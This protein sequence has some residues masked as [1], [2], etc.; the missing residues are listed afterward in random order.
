[1]ISIRSFLLSAIPLALLVSSG[2]R[3]DAIFTF[4]NV[5]AGTAIPFTDTVNGLT[6][7]FSGSGT[8][9]DITTANFATLSGNALIQ[10]FC[11]PTVLGA[12]T[13]NFSSSLSAVSLDFATA[14]RPSE[15][16]TLQAYQGSALVGTVNLASS[17]PPGNF[18]N[19]EG[20]AS[21]SGT[22]NSIVLNTVG[23]GGAQGGPFAI[24]SINAVT[25]T[26]GVPEPAS[27]SMFAAGGVALLALA[28]R[29][30]KS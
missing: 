26:S 19:G 29:I 2:A 8:V 7:S 9:C 15:P 5:A 16:F 14:G 10:G 24:D 21:F 13:V 30:R 17:V 6:A 3:A 22:F 1:M 18:P 11:G 27:L 28:R 25:S 23:T 12:V 4:D 20:V